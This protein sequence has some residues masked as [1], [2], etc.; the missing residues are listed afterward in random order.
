MP[1]LSDYMSDCDFKN[2]PS[3]A[4][5]DILKRVKQS[6]CVA[7]VNEFKWLSSYRVKP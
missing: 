6:T 2:N 3:F 5:A 7:L 4:H 1:R